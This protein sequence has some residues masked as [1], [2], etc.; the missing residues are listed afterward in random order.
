MKA[1]TS[2]HL[3]LSILLLFLVSCRNDKSFNLSKESTTKYWA[4]SVGGYYVVSGITESYPPRYDTTA[5]R[6]DTILDIM[7]VVVDGNYS[8]IIVTLLKNDSLSTNAAMGWSELNSVSYSGGDRIDMADG[9]QDIDDNR[10]ISFSDSLQDSVYFTREYKI[11]RTGE[12][13]LYITRLKGIKI[14]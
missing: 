1:T 3:T 13:G 9:R 10:F 14:K 8:N 5:A 11:G 2:F 7:H 12:G 4:D 6:H